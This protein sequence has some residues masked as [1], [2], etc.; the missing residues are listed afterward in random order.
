MLRISSMYFRCLNYRSHN[1]AFR[2]I[3]THCKNKNKVYRYSLFLNTNSFEILSDLYYNKYKFYRYN[4]FLIKERKYRIIMSDCMHDKIINHMIY[5]ELLLPVLDPILINSNVATRVGKGS[6]CAFDLINKY[7]NKLIYDKKEIFALKIDISKYFYNIDH[8][9]LINKL[10][11]VF[12]DDNVIN[13]LKKMINTTNESYI[14]KSISSLKYN[15]IKRINRSNISSFD[16]KNI[17]KEIEKIPLYN[18]DKG[19]TIGSV[20]SQILAVFYLNDVDHY[21]KESLGC[22]YYIRYMDDFLIFDTDKD[23]LNNIYKL[24]ESKIKDEMLSVNRKSAI[25]SLNRGVS[26]IGYKFI[27]NNNKLV[28]RYDNKTLYRIRHKLNKLYVK[29][30]DFYLR[31]KSSYKGYFMKGNTLLKDEILDNLERL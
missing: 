19:L 26:F 5:K 30:H 31:S 4:I 25:Y 24:I 22:K 2:C 27:V 21:I 9:L 17:I 12:K 7:I 23:K 3:K 13:I 16:K 11:R 15:E 20:T 8:K 18:K 29:D 28:I 14:N 6:G 10:E 1:D